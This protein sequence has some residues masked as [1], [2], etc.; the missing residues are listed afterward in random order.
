MCW[1][2]IG[3]S[4]ICRASICLCHSF[5]FSVNTHR[6]KRKAAASRKNE[7]IAPF[8]LFPEEFLS[9]DRSQIKQTSKRLWSVIWGSIVISTHATSSSRDVLKC[10]L[11]ES[12][13]VYIDNFAAWIPNTRVAA[14][15]Y[16]ISKG[17]CFCFA[18]FPFIICFPQQTLLSLCSLTRL[19]FPSLPLYMK[20]IHM[21]YCNS[22]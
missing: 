14:I 10:P 12:G 7:M 1:L 16:R 11:L 8:Q 18:L 20:Y 4:F 19:A 17:D 5:S 15:V 22:S 9:P 2:K 3:T 13:S 6:T 21:F